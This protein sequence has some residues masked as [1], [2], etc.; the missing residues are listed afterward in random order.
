MYLGWY[1]P[2]KKAA[3]TFKLATA[4]ERFRQKFY[5][6]KPDQALVNPID[7]AALVEQGHDQEA[8][9]LRA[10]NYI[11]EHTYYVGKEEPSATI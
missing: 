10:L 9:P 1:D 4:C 3:Q 2:D 8:L 6:V 5:G 7:Y 11:P